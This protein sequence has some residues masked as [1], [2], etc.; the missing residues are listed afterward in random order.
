[1]GRLY[2]TYN[3]EPPN[4]IGN[5]LGPYIRVSLTRVKPIE[6]LR[7]RGETMTSLRHVTES[8]S[9]EAVLRGSWDLESMAINKVTILKTGYN[10]S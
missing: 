10:P 3:K 1:M 2:Y 8:H 7:G 9:R 4:S 5:D 6:S